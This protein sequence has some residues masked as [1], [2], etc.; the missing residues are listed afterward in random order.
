MRRTNFL[1]ILADDLGYADLGCYGARIAASP[2]ID[3]LAAAGL[4]FTQG[5]ANAPVCS[6][7]RFALLTG[8]YQYRF[9][10]GAEEPISAARQAVPLMSVPPE[11]PT[12][13]S[14][15]RA[16]GYA[17][18]LIG[19]WHLGLPP[20]S[21]PLK[22]GYEE[23]FGPLGGGVDYFKHCGRSG[24]HDLYDGE[25]EVR[26]EGYLTDLI[27]E[28]AAAVIRRRAAD[29]R[30]FLLSVHYTAPHWP[31][32]TRDDSELAARIA[33]SITH[34][35]GGSIQTYYR[36]IGHM[37]EGIGQLARCLADTG[38]LEDTLIVFTS[39]NGGERFSDMW[40]CIGQK[41]D[42]LEG[43]IRVPL[44]A[45]WPRAIPPGSTSAQPAI[46]M[47]WVATM[48]DI[49]G[50]RSTAPLDGISL[51]PILENPGVRFERDL[52]WRML[53]RAQRAVRSGAWKYLRIGK[54]EYLFNLETDA[55][56]RANLAKRDPELLADLRQRY[57]RWE[58]GMPPIPED[59][60]FNLAFT[61]A[62][63]P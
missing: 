17:T 27:T 2:S 22:S 59:A 50:I 7:T 36:M 48:L 60:Q 37:D 12:L 4:K 33:G 9:R 5:Y 21:G 34:T 45:H 62:E 40:P 3:R 26:V 24:R 35:D 15:L 41:M 51:R 52:F 42:L 39:D 18:S 47:D 46:T 25:R 43:G 29:R 56:E 44:I 38:L 6:P 8:R 32:E 20:H 31:W 49:A 58:A 53:Y 55:R 28:R 30:P 16:A 54:H 63:L 23:F 10:G 61:D 13:P 1:F 19:K 11:E 57:A 14:M